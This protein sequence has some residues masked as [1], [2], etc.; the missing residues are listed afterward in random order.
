MSIIKH[1]RGVTAPLSKSELDRINSKRISTW[2]YRNWYFLLQVG[3]VVTAT[4][5]WHVNV[6]RAWHEVW[7]RLSDVKWNHNNLLFMAK[8]WNTLHTGS[9]LEANSGFQQSFIIKASRLHWPTSKWI[10][11]NLQEE[12][13][14]VQP[15]KMP[16][17]TAQDLHRKFKVADLLL[18]SGHC[19]KRPSRSI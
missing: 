16:K 12:L 8:H 6:L 17:K 19:S 2:N 7:E 11:P 10:G 3:G 18:S 14:K 1:H 4:D 5:H 15:L 13:A 9:P